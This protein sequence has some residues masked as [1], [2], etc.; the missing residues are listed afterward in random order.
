[1][2]DVRSWWG[3]LAD[4]WPNPRELL[5]RR[6]VVKA[7]PDLA[8]AAFWTL[9][10][11]VACVSIF[12]RDLWRLL[13]SRVNPRSP[14]N[15]QRREWQRQHRTLM[16]LLA[17]DPGTPISPVGR[18]PALASPHAQQPAAERGCRIFSRVPPEIRRQILVAAFGHQTIHMDLRFRP[19]LHLTDR[20]PF[21]GWEVHARAR[22]RAAQAPTGHPR[23]DRCQQECLRTW[24]W[25]SCVCH[26]WD[27]D[28]T[29]PLSLG[30]RQNYRWAQF[31]EPEAD[32][33][34]G[35]SGR[36]FEAMDVLYTTNTIHIS[37]SVLL[38]HLPD[39]LPSHVLARLRSLE[40]VWQPRELPISHGFLPTN[41]AGSNRPQPLFPRLAYLRIS[42]H[43][44]AMNNIDDATDMM[45]P[46]DNK[47]LLSERLHEN[48]LPQVDELVHRI[49]PPAAEV[50]LSCAR[51]DWYELMDLALLQKQGKEATSMQ[52][53]DIDGL[54][55]WRTMPSRTAEAPADVEAAA[56]PCSPRAGY[57][58]HVPIGHVRLDNS[59]GYDWQ[60][61]E[62]Y[63]LGTQR[64]I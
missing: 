47:Q 34:L 64:L 31:G 21:D 24:K 55:C 7:L 27:P 23:P 3:H 41:P 46:Y 30:R 59:Y 51:W 45:L 16:E 6:G 36:Y 28:R 62:L 4:I 32:Q 19:P 54:R 61:N 58:I 29:A 8:L 48:L 52:R 40:L 26:R 43:R 10:L 14:R 35:G 49:A 5:R 22:A 42:F 17:R 63:G 9:G 44:F 2:Q 13:W 11:A 12:A 53:A 38:Q 15:L 1:M 25:F 60:R 18:E 56:Q 50:T 20:E 57:W 33:C 37:S 39:L